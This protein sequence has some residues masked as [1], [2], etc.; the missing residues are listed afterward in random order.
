MPLRV[1]GTVHKIHNCANI[2]FSKE[3]KGSDNTH[4][5]IVGLPLALSTG[6]SRLFIKYTHS[7]LVSNLFNDEQFLFAFRIISTADKT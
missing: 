3:G 5:G 6:D 1:T 2:F 7:D 4:F